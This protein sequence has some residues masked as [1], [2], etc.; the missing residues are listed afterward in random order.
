MCVV[1]Y[2]DSLFLQ[3]RCLLLFVQSDYV[4]PGNLPFSSS[5]FTSSQTCGYRTDAWC[6]GFSHY[7]FLCPHPP[8]VSSRSLPYF[9]TVFCLRDFEQKILHQQVAG[10]NSAVQT[11][12]AAMSPRDRWSWYFLSILQHQHPA[13]SRVLIHSIGTPY[14]ISRPPHSTCQLCIHWLAENVN[15][16]CW[17]WI[18]C[19]DGVILQHYEFRSLVQT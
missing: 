11:P 17:M 9:P 7:R 10:L 1:A 19:T 3:Q 2:H 5:A 18:C 8:A 16:H 13:G 6:H 4:L 12:K 15:A 14:H